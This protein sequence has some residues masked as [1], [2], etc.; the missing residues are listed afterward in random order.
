MRVFGL[1]QQPPPNQVK[2][3]FDYPPLD[4]HRI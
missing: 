1:D 2:S 3:R 4:A